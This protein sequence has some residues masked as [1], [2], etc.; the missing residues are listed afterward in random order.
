MAEF[1][2]ALAELQRERERLTARL[3]EVEAAMKAIQRAA[4]AL[5]KVGP[6]STDDVSPFDTAHQK[7]PNRRVR[8][9]G[10]IRPSEV[11]EHVRSILQMHGRPMTRGELAKALEQRGVPLVAVDKGK[12]VGTILWRHP[13]MFVNLDKLGYWLRDVALPGVYEPTN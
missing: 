8:R 7:E 4:E 5:N 11:A 13:S 1:S 9:R 2:V 10:P 3:A 6:L 12:N